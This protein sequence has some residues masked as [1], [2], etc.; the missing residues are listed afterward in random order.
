MRNASRA[1]LLLIGILLATLPALAAG[2]AKDLEGTPQAKAYRALIK[3]IDA[4]DFEAYKKCMMAEASKD[5][6]KQLKEMNKTPKE[7]MGF[8]K[9]MEPTD[10]KFT[11]LKVDG[12]KATLMATGKSD[13]EVNK[14]TIELAEENGAWKIGKQSW[15]NA[16]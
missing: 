15:T 8:F 9:M 7:V 2:N 14:G 13:G 3:A 10:I 11:D 16:K 12:K 1:L 6:D 4:Q 5:M